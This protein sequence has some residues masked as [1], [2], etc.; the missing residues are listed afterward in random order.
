MQEDHDDQIYNY[1]KTES[2]HEDVKPSIGTLATA[3]RNN[4]KIFLRKNTLPQNRINHHL[5][6]LLFNTPELIYLSK[7]LPCSLD[8]LRP[9]TR[10]GLHLQHRGGHHHYK[11]KTVRSSKLIF[12]TI[13]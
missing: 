8:R 3:P 11:I 1:N 7:H 9:D 4:I 13:N 12:V 6:G 2:Y 10:T 5:E